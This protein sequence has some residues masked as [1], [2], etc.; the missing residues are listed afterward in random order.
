M[1]NCITS[2]TPFLVQYIRR[3]PHHIARKQMLHLRSTQLCS[4]KILTLRWHRNY[5]K[6]NLC[7]MYLIM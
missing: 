7:W 3:M 2:K 4:Y 6:Y 1:E 5:T